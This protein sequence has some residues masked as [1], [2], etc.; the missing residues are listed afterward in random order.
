MLIKIRGVVYPSVKAAA[1]AHSL[2]VQGIYSGLTRGDMDTVG[3]GKN[4][5]K[6]ITLNGIRFPSISVASKALGFQRKYLGNVLK[7][8]SEVSHKRVADAI[9]AYMEKTE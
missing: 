6:P 7:N 5:P 8:G 9:A 1:E 3:T 4:R 2:T